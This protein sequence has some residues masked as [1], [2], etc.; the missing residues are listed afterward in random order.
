MHFQKIAL[1]A[2]A[3]LAVSLSYQ[4][5]G[6]PGVAMALGALV[7]WALLHFTRMLQVLKRAAHRP[8]GYVDSA[9][10]LNAKLR[11]GMPLL[12]VVAMTRALGA[13]QSPTDTQPEVYAWTDGSQSTVTAVFLAG[14]L[15]SW[16][17]VR[18]KPEASP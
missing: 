13:L 5:W 16:D 18:P 3:V 4:R 17:L 1:P 15:Q 10:M 2:L 9:V 7:M 6:W 12:H 14:K 11:K 8:V